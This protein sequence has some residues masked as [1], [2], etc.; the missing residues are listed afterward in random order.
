M[1]PSGM[2]RRYQ[3]RVFHQWEAVR[4]LGNPI[5]RESQIGQVVRDV[6]GIGVARYGILVVK[7]FIWFLRSSV[8]LSIVG[9]GK[10]TVLGVGFT[11]FVV[12]AMLGWCGR[13]VVSAIG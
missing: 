1:M 10:F 11:V 13:L 9:G 3:R 5:Y 8:I 4:P 7:I 12:V 2:I 6:G